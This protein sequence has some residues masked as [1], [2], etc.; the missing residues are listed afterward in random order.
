MCRRGLDGNEQDDRQG[1]G[2]RFLATALGLKPADSLSL[3]EMQKADAREGCRGGMTYDKPALLAA[4]RK[5]DADHNGTVTAAEWRSRAVARLA[6]DLA[7][8][9]WLAA[10]VCLL[11]LARRPRRDVGEVFIAP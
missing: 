10:V 7:L 9:G 2:V 5:A 1:R 11:F 3:G 4:A 6:A 8:A